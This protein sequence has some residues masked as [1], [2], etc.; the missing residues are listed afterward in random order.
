MAAAE[1]NLVRAL[2]QHDKVRRSTDIP[3]FYGRKDQDTISPHQLLER[4]NRAKRVANWAD[5]E[6]VC[7]E[8]YLCLRDRAISWSNTLDNIPGFNRNSWA[9]VQ[10]EFLA[11]YATKFTA[12]T[13]C[14]SFHDLRQKSDETVQDFYNRVSEV[15]RDAFLVKPDHVTVHDGTD[16]ERFALTVVQAQAL[17]KR[18][19]DNMQ[20]L[21]MNTMFIG[22]LRPD[23][24][25]KV[26]ETGPTR[27][28]EAVKLAREVEIIFRDGRDKPAKGAYI[29]AVH[30]ADDPAL[31]AEDVDLLDIDY[32]DV[33]HVKRI[34]A[35]RR[36]M[37]KPPLKYQ[38]R[39]GSRPPAPSSQN[40]AAECWFCK[41]PGHFQKDCRKRKIAGA[42]MIDAAGRPYASS[43][44]S[45]QQRSA[46]S[47]A[48]HAVNP[49]SYGMPS[50]QCSY[51]Q[52]HLNY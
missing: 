1:Q 4:I 38:I 22:G 12:R 10:R 26:L 37:N 14:T 6:R 21:V 40:P 34:N 23:I 48:V 29:S 32:D 39:P 51:P 49:S 7:D 52:Q 24:R 33:A 16:A 35:I 27:I 15:F 17:M 50:M 5:D 11:A 43:S 8:F 30:T 19:I 44:G 46:W 18:G 47:G 45:P 9:D 2:T 36:K 25:D 3:L 13:V 41:T 20:L 31:S 42:P 28:Q